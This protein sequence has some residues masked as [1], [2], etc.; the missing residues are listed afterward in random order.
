MSI[1]D[2]GRPGMFD[3]DFKVLSVEELAEII[4]TAPMELRREILTMAMWEIQQ[5][6]RIISN[7][8]VMQSNYTGPLPDPQKKHWIKAIENCLHTH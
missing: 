6:A 4:D 1:F 3:P 8:E 7:Q 5:E 2:P